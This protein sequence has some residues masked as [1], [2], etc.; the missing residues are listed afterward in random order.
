M[1]LS[2][3]L[4]C[5]PRHITGSAGM[6]VPINLPIQHCLQPCP[7]CFWACRLGGEDAVGHGRAGPAEGA[8]A[9]LSQRNSRLPEPGAPQVLLLLSLQEL[10]VSCTYSSAFPGQQSLCRARPWCCCCECGD[11]LPGEATGTVPPQRQ[12]EDLPWSAS[13]SAGLF[14]APMKWVTDYRTFRG[15]QIKIPFKLQPG[16]RSCSVSPQWWTL[17]SLCGDT[18]GW[19]TVNY[20]QHMHTDVQQMWGSSLTRLGQVA[21]PAGTCFIK[22][23]FRSR[24]LAF[25]EKGSEFLCWTELC[26]RTLFTFQICLWELLI[27]Y[28]VADVQQ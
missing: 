5:F 1:L 27:Y 4:T 19:P 12:E 24:L 26:K 16:S 7:A 22:C 17:V 20:G 13:S 25:F 8:V 21:S 6:Y 9:A 2:F 23:K 15:N 28:F 18:L 11:N 3:K 10:C 14:G